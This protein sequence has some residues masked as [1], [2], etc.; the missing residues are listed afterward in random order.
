MV[1]IQQDQ[2]IRSKN[3]KP[4]STY[5]IRVVGY[6]LLVL[7]LF[8]IMAILVP[9]RLMNPAWEFETIGSLVE[10]V[11]V[12]LL[13]LLLVFYGERNFRR[14]WEYSFLKLLSWLCLLWGVLFILLIPF[15]IS[16]TVRLYR[17]TNTQITTQY[18]QQ[19]Q[20]VT[21][22]EQQLQIAKPQDVENFLRSQRRSS[23]GKN[24]Q[25]IKQQ[26]LAEVASA[27]QKLQTQ[28]QEAKTSQSHSLLKKS[29]KWNFG[30]LVSGVLFIYIWRFTR[31]T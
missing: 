8:D 31:W 9:L 15:G 20:G 4:W 12:P 22:L 3:D 23:N 2:S 30:A 6:G 27:K 11:A 14:K 17:Q 29:V 5:L 26:L 24:P 10:R 21:Q 18:N 25:E 7:A 28:Y 13:G 1:Q 16:N 19:Q